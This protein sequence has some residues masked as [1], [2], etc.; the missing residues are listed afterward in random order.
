MGLDQEPATGA[1]FSREEE[2]EDCQVDFSL[3]GLDLERF[4]YA[5]LDCNYE[6]YTGGRQ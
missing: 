2:K 4:P 5:A 1:V 6:K 3:R